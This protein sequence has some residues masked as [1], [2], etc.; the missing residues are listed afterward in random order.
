MKLLQ[1]RVK[2]LIRHHGTVMRA[3]RAVKIGHPIISRI[4]TGDKSDAE[5]ATLSK[6]GLEHIPNLEIHRVKK[7]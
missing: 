2:E 4:A 5:P 7:S 6:L 1:K 3:A